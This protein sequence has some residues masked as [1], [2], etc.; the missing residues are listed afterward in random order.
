M[1]DYANLL[2]Q[3]EFP[4]PA[5]L[6]HVCILLEVLA[7]VV[8]THLQHVRCMSRHACWNI[9][10]PLVQQVCQSHPEASDILPVLMYS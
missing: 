10:W 6:Q 5:P 1:H 4:F 7:D 3:A 9:H 2:E 8:H